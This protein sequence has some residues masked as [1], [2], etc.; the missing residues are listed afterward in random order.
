MIVNK[1][2]PAKTY[3]LY[4][5]NFLIWTPSGSLLIKDRGLR[6][7]DFLSFF[8]LYFRKII[9]NIKNWLLWVFIWYFCD[10]GPFSPHFKKKLLNIS[11]WIINLEAYT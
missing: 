6:Y 7:S 3:D 11:Q 2:E 9:K 10:S 4:I 1:W 5:Q 8:S